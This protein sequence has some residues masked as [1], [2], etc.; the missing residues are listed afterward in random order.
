MGATPL[1]IEL[2]IAGLELIAFVQ[3]E[4]YLSG[5]QFFGVEHK[6]HALAARRL[7][8]IVELKGHLEPRSL[9]IQSDDT[10]VCFRQ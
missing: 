5:R 9:V 7:R 4:L 1:G 3:V 2:E 10:A 8:R 6:M